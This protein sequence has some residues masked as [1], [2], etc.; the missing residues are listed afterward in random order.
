MYGK[1]FTNVI[2]TKNYEKKVIFYANYSTI[3]V[4][5][6]LAMHAGDWTQ[7]AGSDHFSA[8]SKYSKE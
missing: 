2:I 6:V 3:L 5:L 1:Y 8:A 4:S 7:C